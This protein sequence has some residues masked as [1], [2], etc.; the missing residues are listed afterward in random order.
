MSDAFM[1]RD[2]LQNFVNSISDVQG[3][4]LISS[5]G[6]ALASV[7][8]KE[9]DEERT[10]AISASLIP[11]GERV[12]QELILGNI[13]RLIVESQR[14]Y[15]MLVRC[16]CELILLVLADKVVK[17]GLLFLQT[18]RVIRKIIPFLSPSQTGNS[19]NSLQIAQKMMIA[20]R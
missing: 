5:D 8:P 15:A 16:D 18:K 11:L 6:L 14:G 13:E 20:D 3:A 1:V 17:P 12:C 4:V 7:L 10:A 9:M 19:L 2:K